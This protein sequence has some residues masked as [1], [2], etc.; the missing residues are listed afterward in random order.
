MVAVAPCG[1]AR[2]NTI[3]GDQSAGIVYTLLIRQVVRGLGSISLS[4]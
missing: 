2:T 3:A 4:Y 1:L